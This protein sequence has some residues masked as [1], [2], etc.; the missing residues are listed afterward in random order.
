M[1]PWWEAFP[2]QRDMN[3]I[4]LVTSQ[5]NVI[6]R[7][8]VSS[9]GVPLHLV[10][11]FLWQRALYVGQR[12][13]FLP[14]LFRRCFELAHAANRCLCK[15]PDL[16]SQGWAGDP[17]AA[18]DHAVHVEHGRGLTRDAH[19]C[20]VHHCSPALRLKE[21]QS[22]KKW[23]NFAAKR[24]LAARKASSSNKGARVMNVT[25]VSVKRAAYFQSINSKCMAYLEK[26]WDHRRCRR[27][28]PVLIQEKCLPKSHGEQPTRKIHIYRRVSSPLVHGCAEDIENNSKLLKGSW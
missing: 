24:M 15:G 26:I 9:F 5:S 7:R 13:R 4:Y 14:T 6:L 27:K 28:I 1:S 2:S 21:T 10:N 19:T 18:P 11:C 23:S 20:S 17:L 22:Q 3:S 16:V 8:R 12:S 25:E